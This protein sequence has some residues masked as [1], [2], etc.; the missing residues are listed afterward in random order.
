MSSLK[1]QTL[2]LQKQVEIVTIEWKQGSFMGFGGDMVQHYS[3]CDYQTP[4]KRHIQVYIQQGFDVPHK[5]TIDSDLQYGVHER[6]FLVLH[7]KS[8]KIYQ[9]RFKPPTSYFGAVVAAE[10][11]FAGDYL[12][13][14]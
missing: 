9:H 12:C 8:Q 6:P 1:G 7:D 14:V 10:N 5:L 4:T 2:T 11:W 3:L 13:D